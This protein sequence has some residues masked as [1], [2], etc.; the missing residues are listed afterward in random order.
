MDSCLPI[1]PLK[2]DTVI[3]QGFWKQVGQN[4]IKVLENE[5]RKHFFLNTLI[6]RFLK[7][8]AFKDYLTQTLRSEAKKRLDWNHI[9]MQELPEK[10]YFSVFSYTFIPIIYRNINDLKYNQNSQSIICINNLNLL[11]LGSGL[12]V[13]RWLSYRSH[14]LNYNHLSTPVIF[15]TL[16]FLGLWFYWKGLFCLKI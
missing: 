4:T 9:R 14:N 10:K 8:F 5:R 1:V 12:H 2:T 15:T 3:I 13:C 16:F 11:T 6:F 7:L